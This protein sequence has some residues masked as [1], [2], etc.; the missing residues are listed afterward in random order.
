MTR[1]LHQ[2]YRVN[3][4]Q[5]IRDSQKA[6]YV[7]RIR[8]F[9]DRWYFKSF[10]EAQEKA[11]ELQD[12]MDHQYGKGFYPVEIINV[13]RQGMSV[14][15]AEKWLKTERKYPS[16]TSGEMSCI[17]RGVPSEAGVH[18]MRRI[19]TPHEIQR[20]AQKALKGRMR[21]R[22]E[23]PYEGRDNVLKEA[24]DKRVRGSGIMAYRHA[25]PAPKTRNKKLGRDYFENAIDIMH[26][27]NYVISPEAF[28]SIDFTDVMDEGNA[29][30]E[31]LLAKK[32]KK[33]SKKSGKKKSTASF[34][35]I[36]IKR[37]W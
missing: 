7:V 6:E 23:L 1:K 20:A 5:A 10:R 19:Y 30:G 28:H 15:A 21:D 8:S 36:P 3:M 16:L 17:V 34:G 18:V 29:M 35:G 2:N 32:G 26:R 11:R 33:A 9:Q 37:V 14:P 24:L 4:N 31:I 12:K 22:G 25:K 13:A 27:K